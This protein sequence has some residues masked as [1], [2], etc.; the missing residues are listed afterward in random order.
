MVDE[1]CEIEDSGVYL[2]RFVSEDQG[3]SIGSRCYHNELLF[4]SSDHVVTTTSMHIC[5][6]FLS[7][8]WQNTYHCVK[9]SHLHLRVVIV[10]KSV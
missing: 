4:F 8:W 1:P 5:I 6:P 3:Q 10:G 7:L 9:T 2:V